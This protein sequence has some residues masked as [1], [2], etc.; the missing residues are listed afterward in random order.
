[1][2]KVTQVSSLWRQWMTREVNIVWQISLTHLLILETLPQQCR[3]LVTTGIF[4]LDWRSKSLAWC[5]Q[6]GFLW[7]QISGNNNGMSLNGVAFK[8][9][10]HDTSISWDAGQVIRLCASLACCPDWTDTPIWGGLDIPRWATWYIFRYWRADCKRRMMQGSSNGGCW[11]SWALLLHLVRMILHLWA[12]MLLVQLRFKMTMT[13]RMMMTMKRNLF[14][15]GMKCF[16]LTP[17]KW[18]THHQRCLSDQLVALS[19]LG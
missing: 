1:M 17:Q 3:W 10:Y 9:V 6:T 18:C 16:H 14:I 15:G 5:S 7:Y 11:M 13:A 8:L 12:W 2:S 19:A 4:S